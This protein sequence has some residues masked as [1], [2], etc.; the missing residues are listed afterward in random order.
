[1]QAQIFAFD[2][3][4]GG[5]YRMAFVYRDTAHAVRGKTSEHADEFAGRFVELV[6]NARIVEHVDFESDDPAFV[7][8]MTITTT[9]KAVPGGSTVTSAARTYL[10]AYA[11]AITWRD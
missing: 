10:A 8:T 1:M 4:E 7:G 2:A 3:R 5:G 9:L 6:A 11:R